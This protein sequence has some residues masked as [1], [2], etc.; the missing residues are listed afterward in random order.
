MRHLSTI[1]REAGL[2]ELAAEVLSEN[3]AMLKVM[4]NSGLS[5]SAK[6][7]SGTVAITLQLT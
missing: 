3:T 4:K 6:P 1:A 7:E 2:R 5:Y